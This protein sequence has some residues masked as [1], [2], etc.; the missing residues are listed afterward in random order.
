MCTSAMLMCYQTTPCKTQEIFKLWQLLH[1]GHINAFLSFT[2]A[3]LANFS[4][5][6]YG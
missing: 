4:F 6:T 2:Q 3:K 1:H 5:P